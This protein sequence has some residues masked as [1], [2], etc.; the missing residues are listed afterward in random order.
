M[1]VTSDVI[2][3]Y[4]NIPQ[5]DKSQCLLETSEQRDDK[6]VPSEVLVKLMDLMQK[7]NIFEFHDGKIVET[8]YGICNE[9]PSSHLIFQYLFG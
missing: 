9:I 2:G 3:A 4:H 5:D 8:N 6:T 1:L 7:H